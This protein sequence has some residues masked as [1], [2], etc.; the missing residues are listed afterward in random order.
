MDTT[1]KKFH[2]EIDSSVYFDAAD[3]DEIETCSRC[4]NEVSAHLESYGAKHVEARVDRGSIQ[5][6]FYLPLDN[7]KNLRYIKGVHC[8]FPISD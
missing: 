8:F 6:T 4:L 1:L 5:C 3:D 2:M 7:A